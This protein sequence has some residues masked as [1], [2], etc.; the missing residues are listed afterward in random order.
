MKTHVHKT[1]VVALFINSRPETRPICPAKCKYVNK[2]VHSYYRILLS[3]I[4]RCAT[5]INNQMV[6]IQKHHAM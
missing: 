4:N 1:S 5:D 6:G 3:N 2:L